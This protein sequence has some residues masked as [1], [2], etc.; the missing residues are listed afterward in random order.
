MIMQW[1]FSFFFHVT[2]REA[3]WQPCLSGIC[4]TINPHKAIEQ[5]K[6][7]LCVSEDGKQQWSTGFTVQQEFNLLLSLDSLS[8]C[9][10]E[11]Y[12]KAVV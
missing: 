10:R 4:C 6:Q 2:L 12:S 11:F 5:N 9:C 7:C 8:C 3:A 1:N